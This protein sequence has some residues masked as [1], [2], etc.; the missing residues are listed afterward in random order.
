MSAW[1]QLGSSPGR[2]GSQSCAVLCAGDGRHEEDEFASLY[3][4]EFSSLEMGMIS[5]LYTGRMR[6]FQMTAS[7]LEW[8]LRADSGASG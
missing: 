5:S 8:Y 4:I 1:R 2:K 6:L 7:Y 3:I